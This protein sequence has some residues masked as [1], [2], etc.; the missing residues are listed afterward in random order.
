M[1]SMGFGYDEG[2]KRQGMRLVKDL[3]Q[4]PSGE[5]RQSLHPELDEEAAWMREIQACHGMAD[6]IDRLRDFDPVERPVSSIQH[7][8]HE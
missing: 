2:A 4:A 1:D 8:R 5:G 7:V 3:G 6:I